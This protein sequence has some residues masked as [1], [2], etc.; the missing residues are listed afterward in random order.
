MK[1][2]WL[3][4]VVPIFIG[5]VFVLVICGAVAYGVLVYKGIGLLQGCHPAII[6]QSKDGQTST[7]IGC[8]DTR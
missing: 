5:A 8:K 2:D 7:T 3:F 4:K 1:G 6:S